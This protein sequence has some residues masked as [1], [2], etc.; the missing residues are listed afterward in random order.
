MGKKKIGIIF[1]GCSSEYPVSIHSAYSVMKNLDE[2]KYEQ[3]L[4]G[5]TQDGI[6]YLYQGD[7]DLIPE[8]KWQGHDCVN[9]I[10]SPSR[11]RKGIIIYGE[12]N[13]G[14]SFI[15]LD[16][17]F[18]VLHGKNGEDG[19]IQGLLNMAGIPI[20]G[21]GMESSAICMDKDL[22]HLLAE[23]AGI[24]VPKSL[25]LR[26]WD[27]EQN[28]MEEIKS[29]GYPMFVKP[30]KAGSSFGITK[31]HGEDQ[32][33][34]A[35]KEAFKYD[36]VII[37]EENI[38][39]FEVGCAVMGIDDILVSP[40]DEIELFVDWFDYDEKYTQFKSKIHIPAR[41]DDDT[42]EKVRKAAK[43][44]YKALGC[45]SFARVDIFLTPEKDIIFNEA[46]TIPGLTDHSR[47]PSMAKAMGISYPD[48]LEKLIQYAEYKEKIK[49]EE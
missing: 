8:D 23:K 39:G 7:V 43:I 1:G 3:Y 49:G 18:P 47:F 5:I 14:E 34:D 10:I 4:I 36:D 45:D 46:N 30:S 17:V 20:I 48:L 42:S 26:N 27:D 16:F 37:F 38:D 22:S 19:T 12:G 25:S 11:D 31:V 44:V 21:C 29:L 6:W 13:Q 15:P 33:I 41:I 35:I 24:R 40:V 9:A 32:L 28:H 2:E